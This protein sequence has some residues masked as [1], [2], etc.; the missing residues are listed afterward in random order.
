MSN[1]IKYNELN[2][3]LFDIVNAFHDSFW[4]DPLFQLERNW[5]PTDVS[6][7]ASEYKVEVEL[8]R[9]KREE[10]KVEVVKSALNVVAKNAKCH[11]VRSFTFNDADFDKADV[12]LDSGV[13]TIV[14][15]KLKSSVSKVLEIK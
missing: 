11:Y 8:P 9:F 6:E 10:I 14:I 3:D 1:V 2:R 7:T 12:R 15:P 5:R 4:N 13:L